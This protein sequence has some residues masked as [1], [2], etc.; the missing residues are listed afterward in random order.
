MPLAL[1]R[2]VSSLDQRIFLIS[3]LFAGVLP[4]KKDLA[5]EAMSSEILSQLQT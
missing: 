4:I 2:N 5:L 1:E 3:A